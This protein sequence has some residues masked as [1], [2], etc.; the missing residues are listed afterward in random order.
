MRLLTSAQL[1]RLQLQSLLSLVVVALM[2][3]LYLVL[4]VVGGVGGVA[5]VARF[6]FD[7]LRGN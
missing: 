1:I 2:L 3:A 7:S 5:F 4:V 6:V